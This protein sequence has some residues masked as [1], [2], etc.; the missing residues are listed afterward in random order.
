MRLMSKIIDSVLSTLGTGVL[1]IAPVYLAVL[2]LLKA[3]QSLAAIVRPLARLVPDWLPAE[4]LLAL[5]LVLLL[6]LVV[7]LLVRT[8]VGRTLRERVE[9][10]L[11]EKLPGYSLFRGL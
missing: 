1:V 5:L 6:C 2:L 3:M 4:G 10:A 7:G 9:H 8:R 11:F